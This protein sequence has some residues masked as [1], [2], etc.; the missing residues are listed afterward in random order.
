MPSRPPTE[1]D[2]KDGESDDDAPSLDKF[3][4]LAKELFGVAR[5]DLKEAEQQFQAER[6][7]RRRP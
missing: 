1:S 7:S 3:K 4:I 5:E 6:E 2:R